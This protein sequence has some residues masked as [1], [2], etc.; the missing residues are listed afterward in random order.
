MSRAG[1][2]EGIRARYED[3]Y[4]DSS[5]VA[6]ALPMKPRAFR[7]DA[8]NPAPLPASL[9]KYGPRS[10]ELPQIVCNRGSRCYYARI[11]IAGEACMRGFRTAAVVLGVVLFTSEG[12]AEAAAEAKTEV[13]EDIAFSLTTSELITALKSSGFNVPIEAD[14]AGE[15]V[16]KSILGSSEQGAGN[17]LRGRWDGEYS[18]GSNPSLASAK[19]RVRYGQCWVFSAT[20]ASAARA[21]G[22]A[23]LP[24][25]NLN[26]AHEK[27]PFD[28]VCEEYLES[29][30]KSSS[31]SIWNFHVWNEARTSWNAFDSTCQEES[32]GRC[33]CGPAVIS[34]R[35][36]GKSASVWNF[37]VWVE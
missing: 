35:A 17:V 9:K 32:D 20:I 28:E 26:S 14:A 10:V 37:H 1:V 16:L 30:S 6:I 19:G 13:N 8:T 29:A 36:A 34:S 21:L 18:D 33:Q 2:G 23:S 22:I 15:A 25:T 12:M 27:K 3:R 7:F 5:L 24:M 4:E 31:G 11:H